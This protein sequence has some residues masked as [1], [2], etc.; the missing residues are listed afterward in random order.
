MNRFVWQRGHKKCQDSQHLKTKRQSAVQCI[1]IQPCS[2]VIVHFP[3]TIHVMSCFSNP[4]VPFLHKVIEKHNTIIWD[5]RMGWN[6]A[7]SKSSENARRILKVRVKVLS[8]TDLR[9]IELFF[10]LI[11]GQ[12]WPDIMHLLTSDPIP[13]LVLKA[14]G[15]HSGDI[16][17]QVWS[18]WVSTMPCHRLLISKKERECGRDKRERE[19]FQE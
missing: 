11:T 5:R 6:K 10:F 18:V 12:H 7:L 4:G 14:F 9:I 16:I 19:V 8:E 1:G 15:V 3:A 13:S 2:S 17:W